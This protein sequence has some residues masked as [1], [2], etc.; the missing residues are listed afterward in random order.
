M[1]TLGNLPVGVPARIL[2]IAERP[3]R[4]RMAAMGLRPGAE[5]RV[6]ARSASGSRIVRVGDAR[7]TVARELAAS[8]EV[9]HVQ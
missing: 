3:Q 9:E 7:L 2:A 4:V 6:L 5:V 8:I 1:T